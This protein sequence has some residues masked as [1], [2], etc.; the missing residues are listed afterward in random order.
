[1]TRVR[2]LVT[3]PEPDGE[4]TAAILRARGYDVLV[5]ALLR[6]ETVPNADLGAGARAGIIMTSVNAVRVLEGHPRLA[7]L[8]QLP[9]FVVGRRTAEAARAAGFGQIAS[10]DGNAQDLVCLVATRC[11]NARGAL[12]YLAG[13]DRAVDLTAA[14]AAHGVR[15]ETV[16]VYRAAPVLE[17]PEPLH[18]ALRAGRLDGALHFSKRSAEIYLSCAKLAG[19]LD[20]ALGHF[21]YCLSPQVAEPLAAAG[22][23]KI[24]I[25]PR[26]EELDLIDLV[27]SP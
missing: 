22:A 8:Q 26:P 13:E 12:L 25:A 11:R 5:A 14:L 4:R 18:A 19:L 16:T 21:H 2:L 15:V 23:R 9:V 3:R 27:P 20:A 17:L 6:V 7:E 1:M 10:A 24:A